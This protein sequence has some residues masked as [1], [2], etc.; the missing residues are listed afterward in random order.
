MNYQRGIAAT[1]LVN[2]VALSY[3]A[4]VVMATRRAAL[5]GCRRALARRFLPNAR[6]STGH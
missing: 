6:H 5:S 4:T 3:A 2:L 1:A